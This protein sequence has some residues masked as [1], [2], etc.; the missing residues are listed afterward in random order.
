MRLLR[1]AAI[2]IA[3]SGCGGGGGDDGGDDMQVVPD[4]PKPPIDAP[5]G[6]VC[7]GKAYDPCTDNTQCMSA[8]CHL[9]SAQAL[10]IC[11]A[12]CTPGNNATCPVDK[13]GVNGMCNNMGICRP[14]A[15]ND[16]TR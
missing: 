4:A 14:A 8:N 10:Q 3:F 11:T 15:A 1:L 7:T 13:T 5:A 9:F 6:N 2:L 16:C 12:T